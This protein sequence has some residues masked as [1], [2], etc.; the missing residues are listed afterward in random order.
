MEQSPFWEAN[1]LSAN[2]EN[3]RIWWIPKVHYCIHK[4][5]PPVHILSHL[6]PVH[7]WT[8]PIQTPNIT[9]TE[10]HFPLSLLRLHQ[11]ISPS[12]RPTLWLFRKIIHFY[13]EELLAPS[14][15]PKLEDHPLSADRNCLFNI[16]AD[17]LHIGG[18]PSIRNL[19]TRHAVVTGTH[20]SQTP[21]YLFPAPI[22]NGQRRNVTV[23]T[24][25]SL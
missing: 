24:A 23:R 22:W 14:P 5:P 4:C 17:T 2:Q 3:P 21:T 25:A 20:W 18:R 12:P 8:W 9:R 13:G 15:T 19:R 11:S 10:S 6:D 7:K 1:S 16:S